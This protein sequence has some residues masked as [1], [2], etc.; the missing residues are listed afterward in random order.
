MWRAGYRLLLWLAFPL[1][2]GRLWWRGRHEPGYRRNIAERFGFYPTTPPRPL[3]WL[4]A[5]SAG[6][7]RAA[8]PLLLSLRT[9]HP[10]CDLLITPMN[11]TGREPAHPLLRGASR[12]ACRASCYP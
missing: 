6:E 1:V 7:T 3:I 12:S 8:E 9:R 11:A 4:H 5:V 2:L 10:N